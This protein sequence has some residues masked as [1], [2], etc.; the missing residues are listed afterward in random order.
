MFVDQA[1]IEVRAGDGGAGC[2]SFYRGK[3]M[4]K[5]GP[6]GG[7]GGDGG[8]VIFAA[9][10]GLSTLYDFRGIRL[11]AAKGGEPGR[12]MQQHG[13]NADDRVVKVP[14]GTLFFDNATGDLLFDMPAGGRWVAA[15]GGRGGFGN[16]HFKSSTNQTPQQFTPGEKGE[17]REMRLELKLIA[18]VGLV[19]LPNAGKSTL[20]R[21]ITRASP[22]VADYPFTTLSPQLGIAELDAAR[23]LVLADIPGLIEGAS[24][25]A[26]LG[27]DFLRHVERTRAILHV[28]DA[29]P[30]DGADPVD[31]YRL[32]RA[33]LAGYSS[34]L[35]EKPEVIAL[36]KADLIPDDMRDEM[37]REFRAKLQPGAETHV[38]FMSGASGFGLNDVLESLWRFAPQAKRD[39]P[40]E[41]WSTTA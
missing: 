15:K 10:S 24:G 39:Q 23:R 38:F 26:G 14:A 3:G 21:A 28:I 7:D 9:E 33:E 30:P 41:G 40:K 13:A 5:G 31:A 20:L 37:L 2:V 25:G 27:H 4:P 19:G 12:G 16:E 34:E 8:D 32:I 17:R 36:N 6:N 22:K 35:A 11:W 29:D 1:I 18:D